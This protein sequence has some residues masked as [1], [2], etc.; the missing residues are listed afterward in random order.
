[1]T[2]RTALDSWVTAPSLVLVLGLIAGCSG[3]DSTTIAMGD[4]AAFDDLPTPYTYA[5][6]NAAPAP[7]AA[8]FPS[9]LGSLS[10]A[11][12][13]PVYGQVTYLGDIPSNKDTNWF[14][15]AQGVAIAPL[16]G[17][18]NTFFSTNDRIYGRE[19]QS[20]HQY[21][22]SQSFPGGN[23]QIP[24]SSVHQFLSTGYNHFGDI[25]YVE[26]AEPGGADLLFVPLEGN[27][28]GLT[29]ALV[30][31]SVAPP[32]AWTLTSIALLSQ[33]HGLGLPWISAWT[34]NPR[35][36]VTSGFNGNSAMMYYDDTPGLGVS[37]NNPGQSVL[38]K[39]ANLQ[40][41]SFSRIQGGEFNKNGRLFLLAEVGPSGPGV[42]AFTFV[43]AAGGELFLQLFD[44]YP[45]T[46]TAGRSE[47]FEGIT[48]G[49]IDP[50]EAPL[51]HI[52]AVLNQDEDTF[53]KHWS[54]SQ[55]TAHFAP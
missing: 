31:Y 36:I 6:E 2:T 24:L 13:S 25:D 49:T 8:N 48:A 26:N 12:T 10:Q 19:A 46:L 5:E 37:I 33:N 15:H 23:W 14:N 7:F 44:Y 51:A 50:P 4:D 41:L 27:A 29:P 21:G 54:V 35:Y 38:F 47:E 34:P 28:Q 30:V 17:V 43:T 32:N 42:Y 55:N 16:N 9:P 45:A 22:V 40:T 3:Q 53:Y 52:H 11:I 39:G 1:M 18:I 20:S